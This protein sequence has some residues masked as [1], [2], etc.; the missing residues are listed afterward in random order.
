MSTRF[1]RVAG[2]SVILFIGIMIGM[3]VRQGMSAKQSEDSGAVGYLSDGNPS[4]EEVTGGYELVPDWPKP[5]SA[6]PGHEGWSWGATQGVFAESPDKVFVIQR[7]ELPEILPVNKIPRTIGTVV[8]L[9]LGTKGNNVRFAVPVIRQFPRNASLD[10][11]ASPGEPAVPLYQGIEGK[12]YRW[13]HL[14]NVFNREGS[15]VESWTQW[16]KMIGRPHK[17]DI[18]PYDPEKRVWIS[19]DKNHCFYVF[20]NDGKKLLMTIGARGE[21]GE[22]DRHFGRANDIAWLPDGTFFITD[23]YENTRVVKFDKNGKFLMA[24]GKRGEEFK[25]TR[26]DYF[27]V[28]HGI[29]ID[30]QRRVYIADRSNRRIMV[31]D[32]NG[33]FITQWY[34]GD[35]ST[36]YD[37]LMTED[38]HLWLSDGH[39]NYK[40]Y[41][42]D[43]TG[44]MLYTFGGWGIEPGQI[45]GVHQ[46][47]VDQEGNFYTAEVNSARAQKFRPKK[48]A[49]PAKLIGQ[50]VRAAWK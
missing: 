41:K 30:K 27:N 4:D 23:G 44:R 43:L 46:F 28:P 13:E 20:S 34:L 45:W 3:F 33:T 48:G 10:S 47:S 15:L 35:I 14:I 49:N 8:E 11:I 7:G 18:N 31:Y 26:P 19:D 50:P 21:K 29:A 2:A 38:Q 40:M 16:D 36:T 9:P 37:L 42:Y 12:D 5:M 1:S 17:I 25:E 39:A 32:E 24:W 6:W 22:D